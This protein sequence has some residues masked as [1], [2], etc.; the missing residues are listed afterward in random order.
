MI[1]A[2]LS[3][4]LLFASLA[5]AI[6]R[7]SSDLRSDAD[8]L[9]V[10]SESAHH[11]HADGAAG[12]SSSENIRRGLESDEKEIITRDILDTLLER[13]Y[14]HL[15]SKSNIKHLPK[16]EDHRVTSLPY[17]DSS[18]FPT[19]HYA[20]HLP[21][22]IDGDKKLFYWLF[23]PETK[24]E[25]TPLLI[26]LNGG[27]GCSSMDG[28]FLEN[29]PFHLVS[30]SKSGK[31]DWSIEANPHS[32]H[33]APAYTLYIDQPVGTGLSFSK[34]KNWCKNDL[35]VDIDFHYFL[36]SFLHVYEDMFLSTSDDIKIGSGDDQVNQRS[37]SRPLYF[38]GES[39]AGH[40]IPSM[41][42]YILQRNGDI[43]PK[44]APPVKINLAGAAIGNGWMDPFYQYAGAE[45]SYGAGLIDLAQLES[46]DKDERKCRDYLN[47]GSYRHGICFDLLDG[48]VDQSYGTNSDYRVS[49]YDNRIIE[50]KGKPRTFPE[51]YHNV[52]R[53]LGGWTGKNYPSDMDVKYEDVLKAL[54]AEE[55]IDAG[56]RYEECTDPPYNALSH[57][58]GLGVT[59]EIVRILEHPDE[60]RLLFFNG[61]NDMICNHVGN[62]K[63]LDNKH[64]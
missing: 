27:P 55:S 39:H 63:A 2:K 6:R 29:G 46:L 62:K 34:K 3:L 54:H 45:A 17:L 56:Q 60:P 16:P 41:M 47:Q 37:M 12:A 21:A 64:V 32:W 53:Y 1:K 24:H 23:E 52:E 22:S 40:Y 35:E 57:Q 38:S 9:D 51:G 31:A 30:P 26:W 19:K 59:D 42:D 25:D 15:A 14:R 20:G 43:D 18:T 61:M 49:F 44:T 48:I 36:M 11:S 8:T 10:R 5:T 50:Y 33:K 7:H 4:I 13:Q 58:D 28:L